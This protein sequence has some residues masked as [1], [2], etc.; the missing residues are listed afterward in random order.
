L[1][2]SNF[3][4]K[5]YRIRDGYSFVK[6]DRS[7]LGGG[8][9]IELEDDVYKQHAHKLEVIPAAPKASKAPVQTP[10]QAAAAAEAA[11]LAEAAAAAA[12][13]NKDKAQ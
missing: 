9:L 1:K 5:I 4:A 11:A 2:V 8:E 7:V 10:A 12:A 3:M 13:A 6:P